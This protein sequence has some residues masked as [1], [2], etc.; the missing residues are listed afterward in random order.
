MTGSRT[1]P[2]RHRARKR[3][4]QHFL[5]ARWAARVV[6][7]IAPQPDQT[8][9]EIGPGTG[10]ITRPLAS[11]AAALVAVEV[12]RDLAAALRAEAIPN[13]RVVEGDVLSIDLAGLGLP[14]G[15]RVAGNLP[16][17]ISTPV[18]FRLLEVQRQHDLF[19][20]ATLMLQREVVDRIVARPGSRD[21]GPLAIHVA[22][23][24]GPVRLMTLPPGAFRPAPEVTS[25]LVRLVFHPADRRPALPPL[26][27]EVVRALFSSRR[28]M[29]ANGLRGPAARAGVPVADALARA[30]IPPNVR[31]ETL[32]PGQLLALAASLERT[33]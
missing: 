2:G 26:F 14:R 27:D 3:F 31:P 10:A 20:D 17:N 15:A 4:G 24:A 18:L 5:E 25:A 6:D 33:V 22:L 11:R 29:V 7:A 13:L 32:S 21:Y 16:Y 28:K 12:D 19:A 30:G 23:A 8:F 1:V 9:L